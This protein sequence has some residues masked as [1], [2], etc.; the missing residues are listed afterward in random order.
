RSSARSPDA[1]PGPRAPSS[2]SPRRCMRPR[3]ARRRSTEPAAQA[4]RMTPKGLAPQVLTVFATRHTADDGV[5]VRALHVN[6]VH[7][8]ASPCDAVATDPQDEHA[9]LVER[10]AVLLGS[11]PVDLDKDAVAISRRP[12]GL[13]VKVRDT[14]EQRRPVGTHLLDSLERSSWEQR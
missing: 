14:F 7:V 8:E 11:R 12:E 1:R 10:R 5:N 6:F 13:C 2:R 3:R 9:T 4:L